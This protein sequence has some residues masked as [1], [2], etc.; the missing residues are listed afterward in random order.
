MRTGTNLSN[1]GRRDRPGTGS[2]YR[3]CLQSVSLIAHADTNHLP[4]HIAH[5]RC[6]V[7]TRVQA[8]RDAL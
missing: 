1:V 7:A 2:D 4:L 5:E 8:I 6:L 3:C